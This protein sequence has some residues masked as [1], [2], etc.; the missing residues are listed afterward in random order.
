MELYFSYLNKNPPFVNTDQ[1]KFQYALLHS[2]WGLCVYVVYIKILRKRYIVLR[3]DEFGLEL[4]LE[5]ICTAETSQT[6]SIDSRIELNSENIAAMM[7]TFDTEWDRKV[8]R[9][10]LGVNRSRTEICT[11]GMD[12]DSIK[13]EAAEVGISQFNFYT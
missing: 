11:L 4:F 8:A 1:D 6:Q 5:M 13:K 12:S 9:V 2:K 3:P 7:N 10:F